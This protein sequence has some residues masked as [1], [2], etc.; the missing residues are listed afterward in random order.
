M[1]LMTAPRCVR[2]KREPGFIHLEQVNLLTRVAR[3]VMTD[4]AIAGKMP[5]IMG[6]GESLTLL[7]RYAGLDAAQVA[8]KIRIPQIIISELQHAQLGIG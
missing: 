6:L 2:R 7:E 3:R 5:I 8:A 1:H 4:D